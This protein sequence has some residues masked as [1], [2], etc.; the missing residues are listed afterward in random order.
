MST[1]FGVIPTKIDE[2]LTF[3]NVV[4]IAEQSINDFLR[5]YKLNPVVKLSVNVHDNDEK[6]TTNINPAEK[7]I[8][9]DSEHAWFTMDKAKGGTEAYCNRLSETLDFWPS[10]IEDVC[11]DLVS[12]KEIELIKK[13]DIKWYF[14]RSAGQSA[15]VNVAYGHLAAALA[16]VTD[17]IIYSESAWDP[18]LF[19]MKYDNFT[20][21]YFRPEMTDHEPSRKWA[22]KC[23]NNM[24]DSVAAKKALL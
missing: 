6:Y 2:R 17:G 15:L 4:N 22:E 8:W 16:K 5:S 20:S 7:F 14:K 10:Y 18:Q 24:R 11:H 9:K 23:L 3:A 12:A 13:Y 1:S 19:P 21:I